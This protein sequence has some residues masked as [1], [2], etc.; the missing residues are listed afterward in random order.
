M[1]NLIKMM[2]MKKQMSPIA[3]RL[4][5]AIIMQMTLTLF[6]PLIHN[7]EDALIQ[8]CGHPLAVGLVQQDQELKEDQEDQEDQEGQGDQEDFQRREDSLFV[9]AIHL[10][11]MYVCLSTL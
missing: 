3:G 10:V 7:G 8:A 11:N 5:N 4:F 6:H 1:F 2:Q 9:S